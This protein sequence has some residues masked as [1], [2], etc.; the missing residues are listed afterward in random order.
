[1]TGS[2]NL[3]IYGNQLKYNSFVCMN[4]MYISFGPVKFSHL[5]M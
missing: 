3:Y 1:M 4:C 2:Y 5:N